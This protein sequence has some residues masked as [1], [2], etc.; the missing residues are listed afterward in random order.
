MT[1]RITSTIAVET[2][3]FDEGGIHDRFAKV[4]ETLHRIVPDDGSVEFLVA[5]ACGAG[6]VREL[7]SG[8]A[9]AVGGFTRYEGGFL[10]A[11]ASVSTSDSCNRP[12]RGR[13]SATHRTRA[14]SSGT[15][16]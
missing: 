16:W 3:T 12:R 6:A 8:G 14:P 4:L 11:A 7:D 5:D 13:C 15:S 9:I 2:F 1:P 10:Q